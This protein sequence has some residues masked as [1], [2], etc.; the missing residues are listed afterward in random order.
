MPNQPELPKSG[1]EEEIVSYVTELRSDAIAAT[2]NKF[3]RMRRADQM[4]YRDQWDPAVRSAND[5][6]GKFTLSIPLMKPQIKQLVGEQVKNPKDGVV[7]PGRNGSVTVA[8]VLTSLIKHARDS[9][10]V[11]FQETQVFDA[12]L[13]TGEGNIGVFLDFDADPLHG[14]LRIEKLNEFECL[15]DPNRV[16]YDPNSKHGGARFFIWEPWVDKNL[17]EMQY[18]DQKTE[19]TSSGTAT[20]FQRLGDIFMARVQFL[21]GSS[22]RQ[23]SNFVDDRDDAEMLSKYRYQVSHTW[24]KRPEECFW[25]YDGR[26]SE[27]D[28]VVLVKGANIDGTDEQSNPI[29]IKVTG[30][31]IQAAKDSARDNPQ[32]FRVEQRICDIMHHTIRVGSIFLEDRVDEFNFAQTGGTMFTVVPYHAYFSKGWIAGMAE[33]MIGTQEEINFSR[34]MV[35]NLMKQTS[36]SGWKIGKDPTGHNQ[37]WLEAHG[38][39]DGIVLNMNKF[40]GTVDRLAPN[41]VPAGFSLIT[42]QAKTNLQLISNVRTEQ[43]TSDETSQSGKAIL[44]KQNAANTGSASIFSNWDYTLT[45][46]TKIIAEIIRHNDVYSD[47]EIKAIVEEDDLLDGE[48]MTQARQQVQQQLEQLGVEIPEPIQVQLDQIQALPEEQRSLLAQSLASENPLF[49]QLNQLID[50]MARPIAE[51]LLLEELHSIRKGEYNTS[52]T[53]NRFALTHRLSKAIEVFDLNDALIASGHM[54][55]DRETLIEATDVPDKERIIER[56]KEQQRQLQL[57]GAEKSVSVSR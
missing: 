26:Q 18:P 54:P 31:I 53:L 55:V 39:E 23:T 4:T 13:T 42:E 17:V 16:S 34:S 21:A 41:P 22:G 3:D 57:S 15:W 47:Q 19:L 14:N 46:L 38:G 40:G 35:L 33:D 10:Q 51:Q 6:K 9:D 30:K 48:L 20:F 5:D 27:L 28:A 29:K 49:A 43:P 2:A 52:V 25:W 50:Q 11:R 7:K 56:G 12:G 45:I 44:A 36:N 1:D 37:A 24:W 8:N 32:I